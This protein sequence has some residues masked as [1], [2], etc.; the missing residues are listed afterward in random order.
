MS[1]T[2]NILC[3]HRFNSHRLLHEAVKQ[4]PSRARSSSIKPKSVLVKVVFNMRRFHSAL[5]NS[6]QP[7]LEQCGNTVN[8]GQNILTN[9]SFLSDDLMPISQFR[10]SAVSFPA[11]CLDCAS[12]FNTINNSSLQTGARGIWNT[13]KPDSSN[14]IAFFDLCHH[15]YQYFTCCS[16]PTLSW[17]FSPN[18]TFIYLNRTREP[19]SPRA[20]HSAPKL[21][22]PGPSY[23]I[24]AKSQGPLH[25][26]SIRP[27]FLAGYIPNGTK[28]KFQW[29]FRI[30][31]NCAGHNINLHSAT[32][33]LKQKMSFN[34]P[35]FSMSTFWAFK[36]FRPTKLKQI[37]PACFFSRKPFFKFEQG[38]RVILHEKLSYILSL[39][40]SSA[41]AYFINI[42]RVV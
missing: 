26:K 8:F 40:V 3:W 32:G 39:P 4:L 35:S 6:K 10:Q 12:G 41:Y 36:A 27:I 15:N 19:V 9:Y 42:N 23:T 5:V 17:S 7:A 34:W 2:T 16:T 28:P 38:F 11:I 33:A 1:I 14:F 21:V 24:T 31:K 30:L 13:P 29:L 25:P 37:F 18:I 20:H 22:Q